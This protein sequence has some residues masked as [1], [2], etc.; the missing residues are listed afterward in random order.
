MSKKKDGIKEI[1]ES[2]QFP[3][4]GGFKPYWS[5]DYDGKW[6]HVESR[7]QETELCKQFGMRRIG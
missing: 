3:C 4:V 1:L 7:N 6:R 2:R 5:E